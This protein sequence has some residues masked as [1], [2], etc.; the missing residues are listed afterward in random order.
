MKSAPALLLFASCLLMAS[1]DKFSESVRWILI[2]LFLAIAATVF[3]IK[4]R[5]GE[6][7]KPRLIIMSGFILL[8]L[9]ITA[10]YMMID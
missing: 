5:Q 3:V 7:S 2:G 8:S 10:G 4:Y 1:G 6:I 9:S